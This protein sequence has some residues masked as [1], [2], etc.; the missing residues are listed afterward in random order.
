MRFANNLL[1]K[2][3]VA[4]DCFSDSGREFQRTAPE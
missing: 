1:L 3:E 4:I 2:D